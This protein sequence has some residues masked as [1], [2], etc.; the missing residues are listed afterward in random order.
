MQWC[1]TATHFK[2]ILWTSLVLAYEVVILM[3]HYI[4]EQF[5]TDFDKIVCAPFYK[6]HL[7]AFTFH[8]FHLFYPFHLFTF[9]LLQGTPFYMVLH[10]KVLLEQ[11]QLALFKVKTWNTICFF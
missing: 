7:L 10:S 8:L 4:P 5:L 11:N 9:H 3:F 2:W 6:V 1:K